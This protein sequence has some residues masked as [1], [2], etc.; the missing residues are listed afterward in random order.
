MPLSRTMLII[1]CLT[2]PT[3]VLAQ[4]TLPPPATSEWSVPDAATIRK[5]ASARIA[6]R[7]GTGIVIGVVEPAKDRLVSAG[8]ATGTTFDGHTIFEIGS[9][10]K[11]FT[12]L[13]LA[14]MVLDGSVSLDDPAEKYLPVG[15][16]MPVYYGRKITLR[17]LAMHLSGLPSAPSNIAPADP[18]DPYADYREEQL[19]A[20]LRD[21]RLTRAPGASFEYSNFGYGLLGY[22]LARAAGTDYATL[23]HKRVT[24]PLRLQDTVVALTPN[25]ARRFP[26]AFDAGMQPAK[27]W[28][29]AVLVG[30]GGIRSTGSDIMRFIAAALDP[31]S[32]I[33]SAMALTLREL[34]P[35]SSPRQQSGL[36]WTVTRAPVGRIASHGGGTGGFRSW[37]A[38]DMA[39]RRGVIV[40]TNTA[41]EPAAA[42]IAYHLIA[43]TPLA[44]MRKPPA[45]QSVQTARTETALS[46]AELD[47][48]V[49]TYAFRPGFELKIWREG[50]G[51]KAQLTGAPVFPLF[52]QAPLRFFWR[53]VDAQLEFTEVDDRIAGAI[54]TQQGR[55]LKATRIP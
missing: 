45:P 7:P 9:I 1:A 32:P 55:S 4:T 52:A 41:V 37:I 16:V 39:R 33:G 47:R 18:A 50:M 22:L 26:S 54:L 17:D 27:P 30:A 48:V 3:P 2:A 11:T 19:M 40:L 43:G 25:Q 13:I 20:F 38:L 28:N 14:S 29:F 51:L 15:A 35:N 36:A 8:A 44:A 23:L 46:A 12:A 53:V 21:Y 31:H 49:G 6:N 42:D 34:G 24:G 10:T 5:I